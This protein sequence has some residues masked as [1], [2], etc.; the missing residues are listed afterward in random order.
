[1]MQVVFILVD[2]AVRL[3]VIPPPVNNHLIDLIKV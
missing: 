3:V 2:F 1:M